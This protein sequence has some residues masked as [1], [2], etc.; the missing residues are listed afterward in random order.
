MLLIAVFY[1][2][3]VLLA[4]FDGQPFAGG[5]LHSLAGL[6][7]G[8]VLSVVLEL[9]LIEPARKAERVARRRHP[10]PERTRNG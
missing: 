3:A 9:S 6:G 2:A 4:V 7:V 10:I 5:A 8:L 1:I